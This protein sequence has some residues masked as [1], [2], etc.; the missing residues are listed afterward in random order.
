LA[1][2]GELL[3]LLPLLRPPGA[4]EPARAGG[5]PPRPLLPG[6]PLRE[7]GR[8]CPRPAPPPRALRLRGLA[9]AER[10]RHGHARP[11]R[12][13]PQDARRRPRVREVAPQG[14]LL[15]AGPP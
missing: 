7:G 15:P 2:G 6:A 4:S 12:A 11:R 5:A 14:H 1:G 3:L 8:A 10:D 9:H 13:A